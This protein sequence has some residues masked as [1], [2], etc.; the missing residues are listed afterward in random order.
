MPPLAA[1]AETL[2]Y[3]DFED[4]TP[5]EQPVAS[6]SPRP[7][8]TNTGPE[9]GLPITPAEGGPIGIAIAP[10]SGSPATNY[11]GEGQFLRL[12][13]YDTKVGLGLEY[14]FVE[15]AS[16]QVSL[17]RYG[18]DFAATSA[19]VSGAQD[20]R[21]SLGAYYDQDKINLS[22]GGNRPFMI[23]VDNDG[24]IVLSLSDSDSISGSFSTDAPHHLDIFINDY[25]DRTFVLDYDGEHRLYTN[26]VTVFLDGEFFAQGMLDN[27]LN[28]RLQA[29]NF[30]RIGFV[31]TTSTVSVDFLIDN[32]E[33]Q[34]LDDLS[35]D[36]NPVPW[37]GD[38]PDLSGDEGE[39]YDLVLLDETFDYRA[40]PL[41]R[42]SRW[43]NATGMPDLEV[44][45]DGVLDLD[46]AGSTASGHYQLGFYDSQLVK[47]SPV[48]T[49]PG[50]R[51]YLRADLRLDGSTAGLAPTPIMGLQNGSIAD[52]VTG[53][54]WVGEGSTT[55]SLKVGLSVTDD[56]A[57]IQ[58]S[59][60][61]ITDQAWHTLVVRKSYGTNDRALWLDPADA[62][63][64]PDLL[65]A[66]E[67]DT[68][69]A[70]VAGVALLDSAE[71]VPLSLDNL[72]ASGSLA[73]SLDRTPVERPALSV[74]Q[75]TGQYTIDAADYFA[76]F[77]GNL[78]LQR[79]AAGG[80]DLLYTGAAYPSG[81]WELINE[82]SI[83]KNVML[84][85]Q[86][87]AMQTEYVLS[88]VAARR[89]GFTITL[90]N[91]DDANAGTYRF[92]FQASRIS[93]IRDGAGTVIVPSASAAAAEALVLS[94]GYNTLQLTGVDRVYLDAAE[95]ALIVEAELQSRE[96]R[97]IEVTPSATHVASPQQYQV[98]QRQ[99]LEQGP[100]EIAGRAVNG[101]DAVVV[102]F[103][104]GTPLAGSLPDTV[105]IP[106]SA[107]G[108]FAE[109]VTLPAGG[110]YTATLSFQQDA[111]EIAQQVVEKFGV[112]EVFIGSGQS[113]S[114]NSG[115]EPTY[116]SSEFAVSFS[117][118]HWQPAA[119]PQPGIHGLSTKGSYY[120]ALL[121][122][123]AADLQVPV[124]IA[125]TG[126]GGT[127]VSQWQPDYEYDYTTY[128]SYARYNGL[129]PWTLHR[130]EQLGAGG[131]RGVLWHQ[132]ESDSSHEPG[133]IRT[134][135]EEYY[136]GMKT[137][138]ESTQAAAG[139]DMPWF[140]AQ[141]S[142][143][144][145]DN[146]NGDIQISSAQQQLWADG[147]ALQG[148]NSDTLGLEYRQPDGSRVHFTPEGLAA[149]A[150]LWAEI[151]EPYIQQQAGEAQ[152]VGENLA[153]A[154]PLA[155]TSWYHAGQFGWLWAR[156]QPWVWQDDW[157]W[158][159]I[160]GGPGGWWMFHDA[161]YEEL[162]WL[163][164]SASLY[165]LFYSA[166]TAQWCDRVG[167]KV[168][169]FTEQ[170]WLRLE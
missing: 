124:A 44:Q 28:Y 35:E 149:H 24:N 21:I 74:T 166:D 99:T 111:T 134:S 98:F 61:E 27:T 68:S 112:G 84:G 100:V 17:L 163:W 14:N 164:T 104:G 153:G 102:S 168:W 25:E 22:N 141:A 71:G 119:D 41:D 123:L 33:V 108:H 147:I 125:S 36:A 97:D 128:L 49:E 60:V 109:T 136:N 90:Q 85:D 162:G 43:A 156:S 39:D 48:G 66:V 138:I 144:P 75:Q 120:P 95:D 169:L 37:P 26:S 101:A 86:Y 77:T 152:W 81:G 57:D 10:Y 38:Q 65:V 6:A 131:F 150:A 79:L 13:D 115:T 70:S 82:G 146:P 91:N 92:A 31:S 58:W 3:L 143:W 40:G 93:E 139:W 51:V 80:E 62:A 160:D 55:D 34:T 59:P 89:D 96:I 105:T 118:G 158:L 15:S 64:E 12:W 137:L 87:F 63:A 113:N 19:S 148:A 42:I 54:V 154:E 29:A 56:V 110:W 73:M 157:G 47:R 4:A 159:W 16:E 32:L 20:L 126:H 2:L 127:S 122:S 107:D 155:G 88:A 76:Q 133:V 7:L 130:I 132:G 170:R 9:A 67:K 117:G 78:Q 52:R 165:P 72:R 1:S 11:V 8:K 135:Q 69:D 106:I 142:V 45:A 83:G 167:N 145:V 151:L 5:G 53:L 129:Y 114:T 30:G 161:T 103:S 140:V 46:P 116:P 121:D 94:T 50:P 18:L 23:T